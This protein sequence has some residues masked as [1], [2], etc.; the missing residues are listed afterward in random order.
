M[1]S[2]LERAMIHCDTTF[3]LQ[4][5]MYLCNASQSIENNYKSHIFPL[6]VFPRWR[7]FIIDRSRGMRNEIR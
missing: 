3:R 7:E 1:S 4:E 5:E 2:I 6:L